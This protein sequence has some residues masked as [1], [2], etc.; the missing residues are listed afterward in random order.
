MTRQPSAL[1]HNVALFDVCDTLYRANT[2]IG[3]LDEVLGSDPRYR[4]RRWLLTSRFSPLF[5]VAAVTLRVLR[6]DFARAIL[7]RSL[8]GMR[9][10]DLE[11][12]ARR[13]VQERLGGLRN[14][15]VLELLERHLEN[16]HRIVLLSSSLDLV[17]AEIARSLHVDYRASR[18]EFKGSHC[19]GRLESDLTGR[20][21][22]L[23]QELRPRK[24]TLHVYTDN[25]SD[26][27]LLS[28]AD[29]PTIIIPRG[30]S[31]RWAK[32]HGSEILRL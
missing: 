17:I 1:P 24:M 18:L 7:L 19:T 5:Y 23:V 12:A 13:Y 3:F 31:E 20:K 25:R 4:Q 28:M 14:Q 26:C 30:R 22:E 2:T 15:S 6:R 9:R 27:A 11:A 21:H 16:G 8:Q 29:N 32:R 10:A